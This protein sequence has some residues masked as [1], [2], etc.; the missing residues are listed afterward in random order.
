MDETSLVRHATGLIGTVLKLSNRKENVGDAAPLGD[1]RSHMTFLAS[2]THDAEVQARLPQVLIGNERQISA[3]MMKTLTG[4]PENLHVWRCKSA[5]NSHALMR[6]YL[7][8]LASSLGCVLKDR[9]VILMLDVA[10]CHIHPSILALAKRRGIRLLYIPASMT[11]ELQPCDTHLFARFKEAFKEAWR[12][13]KAIAPGG[14]V[15]TAQW[16]HVVANAI[17]AVLLCSDW[18]AAFAAVGALAEQTRLGA[19][20]AATLGWRHDVRVPEGFPSV[21][22]VR[23]VFPK[24]MKVNIEAY[25]GHEN[26]V[27]HCAA[28]CTARRRR[29]L[30]ASFIGTLDHP[31]TID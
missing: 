24:K 4:L 16:I 29:P 12:Q 27:Q 18:E 25:I 1:R 6:K 13:Q 10:R 30:P 2:I 9:Y 11:A 31:L 28:F 22:A 26:L 7:S 17:D 15:S 23:L 21:E 14:S 3:A 19:R 8:L 5:W 20:F